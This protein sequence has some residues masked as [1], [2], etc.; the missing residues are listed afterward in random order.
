MI[1]DLKYM[2]GKSDPP[3]PAPTEA[4]ISVED[5]GPAQ[6]DGSQRIPQM[7][8]G[9]RAANS[10]TPKTFIAVLCIKEH[11]RFFSQKGLKSTYTRV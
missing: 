9:K 10:P 5:P 2:F 7:A 3:R 6:E 4:Q 8:L 11:R 1:P